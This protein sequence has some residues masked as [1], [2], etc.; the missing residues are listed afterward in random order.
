MPEHYRRILLLTTPL[1]LSN[2]TVPLLGAVDTAVMGHL[3]DPAYIGGV[4][5]GGTVF[6]FLFWGFGFLKMGT[7]GFAAQAFG[8]GNV[9]EQRA[10][11]LRPLVLALI[12][13]S[14]LVLLQ[15][16]LLKLCIGLLDGSKQV[17]DLALEY[18]LIRIWSAPVSLANYAIIGWLLGKGEPK[19]TFVLQLV[20]NSVNILLD[21]VFV[22]GLGWGVEG[23][24]LATVIA[25]VVGFASGLAIILSHPL[26]IRNRQDWAGVL[27][28]EKLK[29]LFKVNRDIFIRTLCL[30]F[31]FAY[32]TR[33]SASFGDTILAANAVLIHFLY[34]ASY[35]LDGFAHAAEITTGQAKGQNNNMAFRSAVK[36]SSLLAILSAV[37]FALIFLISGPYIINLFTDIPE[38]REQSRHYMI[39]L[40][41]IPIAGVGGFQ[42]D[43]IFIGTTQTRELRNAMIQSLLIFLGAITLLV[44]L[45]QNNGL[46]LSMLLYMSARGLT[47]WRYY[48]GLAKSI[49]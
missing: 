10:V 13:G 37:I 17:Q 40:V 12:L 22:V 31:A 38:V 29:S 30:I 6:S 47:L 20:I 15:V 7:V 48:P 14:L 34:F 9:A 46:W 23:V 3:P 2:L 28:P 43:G 45:W 35:G 25:E 4:A 19:L 21:L 44:P 1:I 8:A 16:P 18:S 11:F 5:I 36:A 33:I 39:W 27:N 32:F 26:S 24:A 41:L 49:G 42:F